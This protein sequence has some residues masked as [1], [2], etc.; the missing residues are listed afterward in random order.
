MKIPKLVQ[1]ALSKAFD[2]VCDGRPEH[3][4]REYRPMM[5]GPPRWFIY[6]NGS[7][8]AEVTA[9]W[10][11]NEDG[12]LSYSIGITPHQK[13]ANTLRLEIP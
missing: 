10:L 3:Y 12:G 2:E 7:I 4:H 6:K 5:D 11:F 1:E 8:V 9:D 13:T